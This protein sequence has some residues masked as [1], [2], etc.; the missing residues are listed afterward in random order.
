[1]AKRR[2]R[3]LTAGL[4]EIQGNPLDGSQLSSARLCYLLSE[5]VRTLSNRMVQE[6]ERKAIAYSTTTN[7]LHQFNQEHT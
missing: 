1:M 3:R 4:S 2:R 5:D 6:A 7:N